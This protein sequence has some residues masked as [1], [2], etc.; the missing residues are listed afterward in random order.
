[1]NKENKYGFKIGWFIVGTL[2]VLI[3]N[4]IILR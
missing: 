2:I 4:L 1:M 3:M